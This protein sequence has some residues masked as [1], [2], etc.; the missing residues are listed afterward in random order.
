MSP[1][2]NTRKCVCPE[3]RASFA[4]L[5][6]SAKFCS[7]DC[8]SAWQNRRNTRGAVF[9]DLWMTNRHQRGLA[10]TLKVLHVMTRLAMYWHEQDKG[11]QTWNPAAK[12]IDSVSW[13]L[14]TVVSRPR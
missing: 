10:K 13:A 9:Y 5:R 2:P 1:P 11:R 6:A 8:N 12:T 4:P 3:C 14:A 7:K